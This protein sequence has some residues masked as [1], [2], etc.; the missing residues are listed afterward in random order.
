[1]EPLQLDLVEMG[2]PHARSVIRLLAVNP[3]PPLWRDLHDMLQFR[4]TAER[5]PASARFRSTTEVAY[6]TSPSSS[7]P[8]AEVP[9]PPGPSAALGTSPKVPLPRQGPPPSRACRPSL[10]GHGSRH[11]GL[12]T[13]CAERGEREKR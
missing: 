3:P 5:A 9:P 10:L 4:S 8:T 12:A 1:M 13:L 6:A 11:L 2:R 7:K